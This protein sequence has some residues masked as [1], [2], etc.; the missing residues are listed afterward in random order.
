[1]NEQ[2]LDALVEARLAEQLAARLAAE[3]ERVRQEVVLQLR[4]EAE[5]EHHTRINA[6]HPIETVLAGLTVEQEAERQR[7][8]DARSAATRARMDAANARVV[9]GM[10]A[11]L[12]TVRADAAGGS[13]GFTI[14]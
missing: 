8:M 14:K 11:S 5:R 9:P 4:R 1:M 13:T 12:R 7:Q 3:R 2:E 6:K 10:R